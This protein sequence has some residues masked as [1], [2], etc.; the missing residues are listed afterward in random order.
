MAPRRAR[1][2][3]EGLNRAAWSPEERAEYE[4]LLRQVVTSTNDTTLR[5]DLYDR[6]I[7]DAIQAQ[8]YWARDI[9]RANSRHGAAAEVKRYQDRI[10]AMVSHDGRVLNL[11]A[12]QSRKTFTDD[13]DEVYQRE[14]IELWTWEQ[15]V[16]K[17]A[18]ANRAK[19]V[20]TNKV[21]HYD[22]LLALRELCPDSA[23][24]ADAA[25]HLGISIQQFL[26]E[27]EEDVA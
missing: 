22:R 27:S 18:E 23:S 13:G 26:G 19:R 16:E 11:P 4:E 5:L 9:Q 7:N 12:V 2:S 21:A 6:L 14:L 10:R 3:A 24:P 15:I 25:G 8:R 1:G 17:R 20:Y